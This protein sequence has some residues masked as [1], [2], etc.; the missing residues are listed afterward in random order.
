MLMAP[1]GKLGQEALGRAAEDVGA[2]GV[3]QEGAVDADD[4]EELAIGGV[5]EQ[6]GI[7]GEGESFVTI[8]LHHPA[9]AMREHLGNALTI[10]MLEC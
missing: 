5:A 6:R 8:L 4:V 7:V 10:V 9:T 1:S 2:L 3:G